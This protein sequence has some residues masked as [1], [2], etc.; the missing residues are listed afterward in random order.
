M[1]TIH[2]GRFTTQTDS[3]FV[4]FLIG[5]RINKFWKL[6][7]WL[8]VFMAMPF[9]LQRLMKDKK[10]GLLHSQLVFYWRGV[11]CI[12]YWDS[13]E[14]LERF[15]LNPQDLHVKAWSKYRKNV[16]S[17]GDVGIWHETY[18]VDKG[19]FETLYA[20]MPTW[21]LGNGFTPIVITPE[22]DT[23]KLRLR[24]PSSRLKEG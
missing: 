8:P 14:N 22:T 17:S 9:M 19:N 12:Q 1:Q 6:W 23:A 15:A 4:V 10:S 18:L 3:D 11:G 24:K 5:M 13:F 16:G 2:K 20:N 7:K 21:G